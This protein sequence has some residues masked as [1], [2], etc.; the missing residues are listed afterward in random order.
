MKFLIALLFTV[1]SFA[2]AENLDANSSEKLVHNYSQAILKANS[3]NELKPYYTSSFMKKYGT[4][5]NPLSLPPQTLVLLEKRVL[6]MAKEM[7]KSMPKNLNTV[8]NLKSCKITAQISNEWT[9]TFVIIKEGNKLLIDEAE[10]TF[11]N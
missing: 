2:H 1:S 3:I 10:S 7:A 8:C 11:K 9:Q 6:N 4:E 5:G